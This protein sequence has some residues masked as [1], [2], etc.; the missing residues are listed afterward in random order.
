MVDTGKK[1]RFPKRH[2]LLHLA[3]QELRQAGH[4]P[5]WPPSRGNR[6]WRAWDSRV[7]T[8]VAPPVGMALFLATSG[9]W[10]DYSN[11]IVALGGVWAWS[12]PSDAAILAGWAVSASMLALAAA[13][14]VFAAG[15]DR[16]STGA[17]SPLAALDRSGV[18][19]G[20][21]YALGLTLGISLWALSPAETD[22]PLVRWVAAVYVIGVFVLVALILVRGV[23]TAGEDWQR[24]DHERLSQEVATGF[25]ERAVVAAA[26]RAI[27]RRRYGD[28]VIQRGMMQWLF[29]P[30]DDLEA[31]S[32]ARVTDINLDDLDRLQRDTPS[33]FSVLVVPGEEVHRESKIVRIDAKLPGSET[34]P[35][36]ARALTTSD[37]ALWRD[38]SRLIEASDAELSKAIGSRETS[39][40]RIAAEQLGRLLESFAEVAD[41]G[42]LATQR[43]IWAALPAGRV[44]ET[45]RLATG[46]AADAN[47][48]SVVDD[49]SRALWGAIIS[50]SQRKAWAA[51][52]SLAIQ[53]STWT[54][55]AFA[56]SDPSLG[57]LRGRLARL[58]PDLIG[59]QLAPELRASEPSEGAVSLAEVLQGVL[60]EV[61]MQ[62]CLRGH[63]SEAAETIRRW[64]MALEHLRPD[65]EWERVEPELHFGGAGAYRS[66]EEETPA[67]HDRINGLQLS[68]KAL[69]LEV[70]GYV[71]AAPGAVADA[72]MPIVTT[73]IG[74]GTAVQLALEGRRNHTHLSRWISRDQPEG[75]VHWIPD[76]LQF[77]N[78]AMLVVAHRWSPGD[79]VVLEGFPSRDSVDAFFA[80]VS[81]L[82][83]ARSELRERWST[84]GLT[85]NQLKDT[86]DD[87]WINF[88]LRQDLASAAQPLDETRLRNF[89]AAAR[90]RWRAST[91][92]GH[93][94]EVGDP[95]PATPRHPTLST[96]SAFIDRRAFLS[97]TNFLEPTNIGADLGGTVAR[98]ELAAVLRL[99]TEH[100]KRVRCR[101][102]VIER[103][104]QLVDH[105]RGAGLAPNCLLVPIGSHVWTSLMFHDGARVAVSSSGG[106]WQLGTWNDLRVVSSDSIDPNRVYLCTLPGSVKERGG[107]LSV[108]VRE[109]SDTEIQARLNGEDISDI[110]S[111]EHIL[112][113]A[114]ATI[115][116]RAFRQVEYL[117]DEQ[118]KSIS[119]TIP[120]DLRRGRRR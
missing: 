101:G 94:T 28:R 100:D 52:E 73:W 91:P 6:L 7:L 14:V 39:R 30:P 95:T 60:A 37:G 47:L 3:H 77:T 20:M 42:D 78:A 55:A 70:A 10:A 107:E 67:R 85:L 50:A 21:L 76:Q 2:S 119:C 43:E 113:E 22:T 89:R 82:V 104:D 63:A 75:E 71:M 61:L 23:E 12:P 110:R 44:V 19:A 98:G 25:R 118:A 54:S 74:P 64:R 112:A 84:S 58:P 72:A 31:E 29:G 88:R 18:L 56:R 32:S 40:A 49:T 81:E 57:P 92:R 86:L 62:E 38:F 13:I 83:E 16:R 17:R 117:R 106:F 90:E 80:G 93:L 24:R 120:L 66:A 115:V 45:L 102:T 35:V 36:K 27:L 48:S 87:A 53:A 4:I 103:L 69:L 97:G 79:H 34:P 105:A 5:V 111:E 96:R 8:L 9:I 51:A 41:L 1:R 15:G 109:L 59:F 116:I 108:E 114:R 65:S 33:Q 68:M 26:A 99:A 11:R 46:L